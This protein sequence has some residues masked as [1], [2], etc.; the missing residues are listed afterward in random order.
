MGTPDIHSEIVSDR[1]YRTINKR[2]VMVIVL[3]AILVML[4]SMTLTSSAFWKK[5][6]S[7]VPSNNSGTAQA[8]IPA[9]AHVPTTQRTSSPTKT[10]VHAPVLGYPLLTFDDGPNPYYTPQ[11]LAILQKYGVK[12]TFFDVGYLVADYPSIVRQECNEGNI[13][14]NHSWSHPVLTYLAAQAILSQLTST[15]KAI[16]AAIGVRP[17]FFRPPYGATNNIVL[18]QA[19][20]LGYTTVLWDGSAGDWKLP[21][22]GVITSKLLSYVRDGAILLLHDGG[23][24]RAQT[25]AALPTIITT[26]ENRGYKFVTI[27]KL[28]DD[29]VGPTPQSADSNTNATLSQTTVIIP[30]AW[31]RETVS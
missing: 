16:Q 11:V 15:T 30:M 12:A 2:I 29:L 17:T 4:G 1:L 25:V 20:N 7:P 27:Q 24:N 26:L 6:P 9:Q 8:L 5:V 31:R 13:V 21:G 3:S 22:V 18:T 19:R 10:P 14:A 28:V 23:G